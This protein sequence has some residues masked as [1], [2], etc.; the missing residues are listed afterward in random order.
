MK[1]GERFLKSLAVT[2]LNQSAESPNASN[3]HC[4]QLGPKFHEHSQVPDS[5][6]DSSL[7]VVPHQVEEKAHVLAPLQESI[8]KDAVSKV[9]GSFDP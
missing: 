1:R 4:E 9:G 2:D 8:L 6:H 3:L 5:P 7:N